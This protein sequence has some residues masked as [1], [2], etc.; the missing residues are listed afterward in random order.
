[1]LDRKFVIEHIDAVLQNCTNRNVSS[2]VSQI[3]ELEKQR[4]EKLQETEKLN[5]EAK[6]ASKQIGSAKDDDE[7]EALKV[8]ARELRDAKDAAQKAHDEID[9][10][11]REIELT[12][13]N[14]AH[15]DC[16]IG[17]DDR[18]TRLD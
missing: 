8:G 17:V 2:D 7:R 1:M 4:R 6:A 10:Q 18:E 9:L 12:I 16:P 5:A 15:P 11:I 3:V 13:P 14:M